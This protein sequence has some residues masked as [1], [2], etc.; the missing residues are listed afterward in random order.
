MNYFGPVLTILGVFVGVWALFKYV[1]L[2]E[3]RIDSNT[4]KT[5]YDISKEKRKLILKEEFVQEAKYPTIYK[6]ICFFHDMPWFYLDHSE[7]LLTAGFQGKDFTTHVT[8]FRWSYSR[9]KV[10]L[11]VKLK[12]KQLELFG[13]PVE[14]L[15]PFYCDLIG[16]LKHDAWEPKQPKELWGDIER[17]FEEVFVNKTR[18]KTS[19]LLYGPPGNGK[20][21]IVK[22]LAIKYRVPIRI[23]T[24]S[25]EWDNYQIM[26]MFSQ[27]EPGGIVLLEDFDNYF[28]GR[29]CIIG[30]S[31][32]ATAEAAGR[33]V[34]FTFD[35]ILNALDGVYN[36]YE[37]TAF[38]MTVNHIEK[39]DPALKSRP[40]R[41]K[42]VR[43]F[44][45]PD[46][47]I[48]KNLLPCEWLEATDGF[49]LDQVMRMKEYCESGL[50][51]IEA[52]KKLDKPSDE[53]VKTIAYERYLERQSTGID[54]DHLADW[55]YAVKKAM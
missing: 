35:V 43:E 2:V 24:F 33:Y 17:E 4:F 1:I 32:G 7:R 11:G 29:K 53:V 37:R 25:P 3:M 54:G 9:L 34:K 47:P 36:T 22:Y 51:L 20:T 52:L 26:L 12:E 46:V 14:I 42:F 21:S 30:G 23:V 6:I 39:V 10:E 28:D 27:I 41:F 8:C 48:R 40:S 15:M 38:I 16:T 18:A 50:S 45:N 13:I 44:K 31:G 49:N 19:A 5:L 55:T